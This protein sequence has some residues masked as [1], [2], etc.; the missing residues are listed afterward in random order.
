VCWDP[1]SRRAFLAS[2]FG[3][4][5]AACAGPTGNGSE[6]RQTELL[7][8]GAAAVEGSPVVDCHAHPGAFFRSSPDE[9]PLSAL[10]EMEAGGV[11]AA[12]FS[13]VTDAPVI[14]RLPEGGVRQF[15]EPAPGELRRATSTQIDRVLARVRQRELQLVLT[16]GDVDRARREGRR[17]ALLAFEGADP[18]DGDPVRVREYH[19]LGVRSIQ[20]VH[21]RIN[22]LGDIQTEPPRH[23]G[24]TPAG[25]AVVAELNRLHMIV[26]GA[27]AAAATLLG[28]LAASR[29]P[30]IVS[31]TGPAALRPQVA[32]HLSDD[33]MR[34]VAAKGGVIG[35]WP[36]TRPGG[37][38]EQLL[39]D[40]DYVRR[41][42]GIDH[43]GVGTDMAGLATSTS[44]PTYREF[45]PV[46][47]ALL[48]RGFS[49][50]EVRKV[51]GGNLLRVFEAVSA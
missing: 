44:I 38:I 47:A 12:L 6:R 49:E 29:H 31:H 45:A 5:A 24:L 40:V 3:A 50:A 48:A 11:D 20:L 1:G 10:A 4:V 25:Q 8:Q 27:H 30:I 36:L 21:Y 43:V 34:A 51:L 2:V 39:G 19:G 26:D 17:A 35:V 37:G 13:V 7:A 23:G 33:L 9:L 14:R 16:P 22:E 42:V 41:L 15:R 18:L 28:I 46:S 32:R